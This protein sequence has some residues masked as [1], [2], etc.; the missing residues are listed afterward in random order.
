MF[1]R[2]FGGRVRRVDDQ[3]TPLRRRGK[4]HGIYPNPRPT[5]RLQLGAKAIHQRAVNG[6]AAGD[7]NIR[8]FSVFQVG[9]NDHIGN[10][11]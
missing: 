1:G 9:I 10:L 7:K 5:D 3:N 11:A 8:A 6:R 2:R 4:I